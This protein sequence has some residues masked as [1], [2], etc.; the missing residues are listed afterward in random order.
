MNIVRFYFPT[1]FGWMTIYK[2]GRTQMKKE[3]ERNDFLVRKFEAFKTN[4]KTQS[5]KTFIFFH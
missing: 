1:P 4:S 2:V 5:I 3:F